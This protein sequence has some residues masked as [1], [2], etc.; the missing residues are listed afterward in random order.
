MVISLRWGEE[1]TNEERERERERL[2]RFDS[3]DKIR[4]DKTR[5]DKTRT[6]DLQ[7]N[8]ECI[9]EVVAANRCLFNIYLLFQFYYLCK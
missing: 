6:F 9:H 2:I 5:Q 1:V 4:Q 7:I 8:E 3:Q